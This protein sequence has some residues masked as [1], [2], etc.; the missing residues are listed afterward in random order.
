MEKKQK[1]MV[2]STFN[3]PVI[4]RYW[5]ELDDAVIIYREESLK[6]KETTS[7][8]PAN[9]SVSKKDVFE[10]DSALFEQMK[11]YDEKIDSFPKELENLWAKAIP[12]FADKIISAD[13]SVHA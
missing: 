3:Q 1:I 5:A 6:D 7:L 2:R 11:K 10:Y 4:R 12:F 9:I 13:I 8:I